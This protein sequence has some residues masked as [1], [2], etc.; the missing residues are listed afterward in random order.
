MVLDI[1]VTLVAFVKGSV[2]MGVFRVFN[3]GC[4]AYMRHLLFVFSDSPITVLLEQRSGC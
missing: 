1:G 4:S 2:F 3:F